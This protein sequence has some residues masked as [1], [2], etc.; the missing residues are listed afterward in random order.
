MI[1]FFFF[2]HIA[3]SSEE[4]TFKI[5]TD[6]TD[7]IYNRSKSRQS[8][9]TENILNIYNEIS[10]GMFKL[11]KR[12]KIVDKENDDDLEMI[13]ADMLN[14]SEENANRYSHPSKHGNISHGKISKY[15]CQICGPETCRLCDEHHQRKTLQAKSLKSAT[16]HSSIKL[17]QSTYTQYMDNN[18]SSSE[19]ST[20]TS[21]LLSIII[22]SK[23]NVQASES[24]I[25]D[26][27]KNQN[28][29]VFNR[30]SPYNF[31][32]A[33]SV[34]RQTNAT[35]QT[36]M[37]LP[38]AIYNDDELDIENNTC[39]DFRDSINPLSVVSNKTN[40]TSMFEEP[41]SKT[42]TVEKT[43]ETLKKFK[44]TEYYFK[45]MKDLR[46]KSFMNKNE[47]LSLSNTPVPTSSNKLFLS[48]DRFDIADKYKEIK[49]RS[50][51][52]IPKSV[53][54]LKRDL[55]RSAVLP[56]SSMDKFKFIS[57]KMATHKEPEFKKFYDPPLLKLQ[58]QKFDEIYDKL[59]PNKNFKLINRKANDKKFY[60][61]N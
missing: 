57:T 8:A 40:K 51:E 38:S 42:P 13:K 28:I 4:S 27:I 33:S 34:S 26:M 22:K 23:Y 49:K 50:E 54:L 61:D 32:R 47:K 19:S 52:L 6:L 43:F 1:I 10:N 53:K 21:M 12:S 60:Y 5:I 3:A 44:P 30:S 55:L 17:P 7:D 2:F 15:S 37:T 58:L 56:E 18:N 9:N 24:E 25:E 41:L 39:D 31:K 59:I 29:Y 48:I 14:I 20:D 45:N 36:T 16:S 35:L 46:A 11:P